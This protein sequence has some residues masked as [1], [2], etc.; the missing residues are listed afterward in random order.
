MTTYE[1]AGVNVKYGD[2]VS[3]I[4]YNSSKATWKN[5]EGKLGEV[6]VPYDSFSGLRYIDV[7]KLPEG[8]VMNIGFDGIGTK[9]EIAERNRDHRYAGYDLLAMVCDDAVVRGAEPVLVGS[10]LDINSLSR[11]DKK[12][13]LNEVNQLAEGYV[14]EVAELKARVQGYGDF[15]YNWGAGVVWFGNKERLFTGFEI[16]EGDYLISLYERGFRSNGISLLRKIM[17]EKKGKNW[18]KK[19][20]K[21]DKGKTYGELVNVPSTIYSTAVVDMFGGYNLERKPRAEVHGV[22]HITGGGIPGKLGRVLKPSGLGAI[23]DNPFNI[24]EIM[25]ETMS[26]GKVKPMEAYKTWCMA[27]GMIIITP[28]PMEVWRVTSEYGIISSTIGRIVKEPGIKIANILTNSKKK[29]Y[30]VFGA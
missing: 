27:H 7:S 21:L 12:P 8:T 4:L 3:K 14:G 11:K 17:E 25:L 24:P 6:I 16:K 20:F 13:F 1:S 28:E 19:E 10:I 22:T 18:H 9:V 23:I 29:P 26:L 30:F 5:R 2:D 15:N